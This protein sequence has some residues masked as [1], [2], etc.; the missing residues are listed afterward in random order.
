MRPP[1]RLRQTLRYNRRECMSEE[2]RSETKK[3]KARLNFRVSIQEKRFMVTTKPC[4][5]VECKTYSRYTQKWP[6]YLRELEAPG[7]KVFIP[8]P[9]PTQDIAKCKRCLVACSRDFFSLNIPGIYINLCSPLASRKGS[10]SQ[11]L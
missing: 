5:W 10:N 8:F 7:M 4:C 1:A 6:K 11:I 2:V 3:L 9:K